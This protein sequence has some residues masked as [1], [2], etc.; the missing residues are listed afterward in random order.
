MS[1]FEN[2]KGDI[3]FFRG[4]LRS[5]RRTAPIIKQPQRTFPCVIDELGQRFGDAPALLSARENFSYRALAARTNQYARWALAQN[6]AEGD[7]VCLLMPNRPEYLAIWL[8]VTKI[9]GI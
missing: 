8:G 1:F 5:L 2:V 3:V 6:L 9:G 4:A 7:V